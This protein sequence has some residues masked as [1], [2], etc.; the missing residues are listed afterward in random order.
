MIRKVLL[1]CALALPFP[2]AAV[3][4]TSDLPL[5]FAS[6][7]PS[8][9][10]PRKIVLSLSERD[11]DRVNEVIGNVGN[12]QRFYGADN[13][14]IA[15]IVYGPGI[16][17]VLTRDTTVRARIAGLVAIGVDVLACNATLSTLHLGAADVLPGVRVIPNGLP[18]IVE[19][20][21]A[22][23]YYVRP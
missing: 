17:A 9:D 16:H 19:F 12:I 23:W 7:A 13:V 14:R 3:A 1:A 2:L 5:P 21:A 4:D 15:L 10:H 11:P 6:P 22:G 8:F 20:Q 18:A